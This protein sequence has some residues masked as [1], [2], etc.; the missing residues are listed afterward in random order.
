ML[1]FDA[2]TVTPEEWQRIAE[3][4]EKPLCFNFLLLPKV[5]DDADTFLD[6][7][8]QG[9]MTCYDDVDWKGLAQLLQARLEGQVPKSIK[10]YVADDGPDIF[11]MVNVRHDRLDTPETESDFGSRTVQVLHQVAMADYRAG[12]LRLP[13][14]ISLHLNPPTRSQR[15]PIAGLVI[16]VKFT[17]MLQAVDYMSSVMERLFGQLM[18]LPMGPMSLMHPMDEPCR[19]PPEAHAWL[20]AQ[21]G[22]VY[23]DQ[24]GVLF[25]SATHS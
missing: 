19:L 11:D 22:A 8:G 6:R 15:P 14:E 5:P 21:F 7:N 24:C 18:A 3:Q 9:V 4:A 1:P 25:L 17:K 16:S 13:E 20:E 2:E 10:V 12:V 23:S